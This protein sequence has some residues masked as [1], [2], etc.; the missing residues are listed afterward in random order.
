MTRF[1]RSRPGR[2]DP[3][4][5]DTESTDH[6]EPY[7]VDS[8]RSVKQR[9]S[10]KQQHSVK[11]QHSVKQRGSVR[12]W[13]GVG[14]WRTAV[15]SGVFWV[16]T[17]GLAGVVGMAVAGQRRIGLA[18]AAVVLLLG[19]FASDPI[20]LVVLALPGSIL[21]ERLGGSTNFSA[22]DLVVFVGGMVSLFHIR[23]KEATYLR[24]FMQGVIW[25]EAVLVIIV[26]A[27]PN[28]YDIVEWF[29]R[30]S[31]LGATVLCG[32]VIAS[33]DRVRQAFR[34]F[35]LAASILAVLAIEHSI[36]GHFQPAQW[37]GYQKN[38]IGAVMWV[39][40]VVAQVNPSWA[41]VPRMEAR[42]SKYLCLLG[43]LACQSRQAGIV[44]V[45]ALV[46]AFLRNPLLRARSKLIVVGCIPVVYLVYNSFATA[47]RNNPRFNSVAIR[48]NQ[49]NLAIHVWHLA[50]ILGEGMR[51]YN[52]PQWQ[53]VTVPPNVLY[54]NLASTGIVGSLAFF[55]LVWV[56]VRTMFRIPYALGTLGLAV[57][58]AHYVDGLFD[59]FWI[60]AMY[61]TPYI[62]C[63]VCLGL[64]DR[65]LHERRPV[66]L[67]VGEGT[68]RRG[69]GFSTR[70]RS[71]V[72][73]GGSV[74]QT[75]S[76]LTQ[77]AFRLLPAY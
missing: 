9:H 32:W 52:L 67:R 8:T 56:T 35:L 47:A 39:A 44:M 50:P 16:A 28:R 38:S 66:D 25:Y 3:G 23:W 43:L 46:I 12:Q 5:E 21:I 27:N 31:G 19:I 70:T 20:L 17:V 63:G 40:V 33:S 49:Y 15:T 69:A 73:P 22:G 6:V 76:R 10:V 14:H 65:D 72:L 51:F 58:I 57:L 54:D 41:G 13:S 11:R 37:S 4:G 53:Y 29:H 26:I 48:E 1:A 55:Y 7:D 42:V 59:I 77:A 24:Q 75:T 71:G 64:A 60:G 68:G 45:L 34:L 74:R 30:F 62:I 61:C 36:T 2:S 18:L